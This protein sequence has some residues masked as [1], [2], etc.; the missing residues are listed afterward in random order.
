VNKAFRILLCTVLPLVW[1]VLSLFARPQSQSSQPSPSSQQPQA[2]SQAQK[3]DSVAEAARKAKA[4]KAVPA[5]GKVFTE[6]D[7]SGMRKE[8][9]SVVG[10]ESKKSVQAAK[11]PAP[12]SED[13]PNSEQYW[14]EKARPILEE[15]AA[16]NQQ[17]EQLKEDIKKYG[18]AGFDVATGMKDNIAYVRDRNAKIEKL[19]KRKTALEKQLDDLQDEGRKAGAE[20]AWFR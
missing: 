10:N 11:K 19:Q 12:E 17:I 1:P 2:P 4:K 6:D 16:V 8:G 15:I 13:D 14:R 3:E 18:N 7:L 5:Q 20:P 9:V